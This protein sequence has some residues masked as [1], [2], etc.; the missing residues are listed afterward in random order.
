[1]C[2]LGSMNYHALF[3]IYG[4]RVCVASTGNMFGLNMLESR[5][6]YNNFAKIIL[7]N[8]NIEIQ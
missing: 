4:V 6:D 3:L 2:N 7:N 1:M 8:D 5:V